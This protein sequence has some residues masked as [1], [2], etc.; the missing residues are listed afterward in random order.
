MTTF[1]DWH[2]WT[3]VIIGKDRACAGLILEL[4]FANR[5]V[6]YQR[7]TGNDY[8]ECPHPYGTEE[9]ERY[10]YDT[11]AARFDHIWV[12]PPQAPRAGEGRE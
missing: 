1:M 12:D 11:I 5:R 6:T 7:E 9:Y 4:D 3:H 8:A 10:L 2:S